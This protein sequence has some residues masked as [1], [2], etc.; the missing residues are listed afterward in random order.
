MQWQEAISAEAAAWFTTA[1]G[2][3]SLP[4]VEA[5]PLIRQGS[6]V[7]VCAPTGTGKTMCAFLVCL[8]RLMQTPPEER[9]PGVSVLYV[10]PLKS[11]TNDISE[12]LQR[13]L[14][15][16][17]AAYQ[18]AGRAAYPVNTAV[19][20]G[21][22]PSSERAR[23]GRKPPDVLITTPESLYLLLSTRSGC[24]MLAGVQSVIVDEVHALLDSK[25]GTHLSL[26]LERLALMASF[27][28]IGLSATVHDTAR[29]GAWMCGFEE[30]GKPRPFRVVQPDMR[31]RVDF[32]VD[33]AVPDLRV[34]PESTIWPAVCDRL[35]ELIE[36]HRT[37]LVFTNSRALAEK[38]ALGVNA[39]QADLC[40]T[41]HGCVSKDMRLA[42]EEALR[43][44]SLR[45]MIATSSMELGIDV[46]HVDLVVQLGSPRSC[47]RGL[48]R[49]GRAGHRPDEVSRMILFAKNAADLLDAALVGDMMMRRDIEPAIIPEGCLDVLAQHVVASAVPAPVGVDDFYAMAR[50]AYPFRNLPRAEYE[51]VLRMLRGDFDGGDRP[52]HPRILYEEKAGVIGVDE[53]G[54]MLARTGSTIPD[55]GMY[56]VALEDGT[57][58]GELDEEFVFEARVGD[59]FMLGAFSW[60]ITS[61]HHDRVSVAP[62]GK[63]GARPP[64]WKGDNI[65]RPYETGERFGGEL[66]ALEEA[67][68]AGRLSAQ[69][70]KYPLSEDARENLVRF[71]D[72]QMHAT[73][74]MPAHD[75]LLIEHY[76]DESGENCLIYTPLGGRI[77]NVLALLLEEACRRV[78]DGVQV[79]SDDDGVL[80]HSM[81]GLLPDNPLLLLHA[82]GLVDQVARLLPASA[83]FALS[84]RYAANTALMLGMRSAQRVPL[85][86]QRLR[87][88]Q[89]LSDAAQTPEHP[90]I[91]EAYRECMFRRLDLPRAGRLLAAVR[92]GAV[93][94]RVVHRD[95]PSPMARALQFAYESFATYDYSPAPDAAHRGVPL[96][97]PALIGPIQDVPLQAPV[98]GAPAD[99]A[100]LVHALR[101]DAGWTQ[102][103]VRRA[104]AEGIIA[105]GLRGGTIALCEPVYVAANDEQNILLAQ[106]EAGDER[107]RWLRRLALARGPLSAADMAA[108]MGLEQAEAEEALEGER[109]TGALVRLTRPS[110]AVWAHQDAYEAARRAQI[111][112]LRSQVRTAPP[113]AYAALLPAWQQ[114][115]AT[116]GA[117]VEEALSL[118]RG[119]ALPA[120]AWE[121]SVLPA[122][123]VRYRPEW[124]D[125]A[126]QSGRWTY[127]VQDGLVSFHPLA[128]ALSGELPAPPAELS[129]EERAVYAFL[130]QRGASFPAAIAACGV[131]GA[132]LGEALARLAQRGL[133][134]CDSFEPVRRAAMPSFQPGELSVKGPRQRVDAQVKRRARAAADVMGSA[135]RW[136]AARAARQPDAEERLTRLFDRFA[137]VGRE[138]AL[139]A[140]E[141]W[142]ALLERLR[143]ME[144]EGR[145]RRGYFVR[146]MQGMQFVR[147]AQFERIAAALEAPSADAAVCLCATDPAQPYGHLLP[148]ESD[149]RFACVPGT[150]VVLLGGRVALIV[151]RQGG[152]AALHTGGEVNA[153]SRAAATLAEAFREGRL[154][155]RLSHLTVCAPDEPLRQALRGAGFLP[156]M[157]DMT[158]WR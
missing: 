105:Q 92:S 148:H 130:C 54:R 118:L 3:P 40:R 140:G 113:E 57:R 10:S 32:L 152:S 150:G 13:P 14:D 8:D 103:D 91:L 21:D 95:G 112:Q 38:V 6:S 124:L 9:A 30:E 153:A 71:L 41:H 87:G 156:E 64:F 50:R 137:L 141:P 138:V 77:N 47:A 52:H 108:R 82:E 24:A 7:L 26:S 120:N 107:G 116:G 110:G 58:L 117:R 158:L 93:P 27:Q 63:S 86:V 79:V 70:E 99:I 119:W 90:L 44:G 126:L 66:H 115:T 139:R 4:Q 106:Q 123:A 23:M 62:T 136:E 125:R 145:V 16:L 59:R 85:W 12:N 67:A 60:Q 142:P 35:V 55:R 49:M 144:L 2:Q 78:T 19:R 15:G 134:V 53:Y 132:K 100:G 1:L 84:F 73:D 56:I 104:G 89:V 46:G 97:D 98:R 157:R 147:D 121:E 42:A 129:E 83:M 149:R 114:G 37:T 18:A 146:G 69:V 43:D 154:W 11:L 131:S 88:A 22:T 28:R 68:Q 45:C 29:A 127:R 36:Q 74:A 72:D 109:R 81:N 96:V 151:E 76:S 48:Q 34:L 65:D 61:I 111:R 122:R 39:R 5:W 102:E 155:P 80:L 31:K 128:D 143:Q 101:R 94:V 51:S 33:V 20:T 133:A 135:G 25:R 17:R 75:R